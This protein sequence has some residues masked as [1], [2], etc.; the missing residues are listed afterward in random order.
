M[1]TIDISGV[2]EDSL[3]VA[4]YKEMADILKGSSGKKTC[5][6]TSDAQVS[7]LDAKHADSQ[8]MKLMFDSDS[9]AV[10]STQDDKLS[11][12]D[13]VD[14]V[15]V[16]PVD[17]AARPPTESAGGPPPPNQ[18]LKHLV[19]DDHPI[20]NK[21]TGRGTT[22]AILDSGINTSHV[23]FQNRIS[24]ESRSFVEDSIEDIIGHGTQCAGLICG[25]TCSLNING[26]NYQIQGVAPDAKVVMC[27]VTKVLPDGTYGADIDACIQALDHILKY[28][29]RF[30]NVGCVADGVANRVSVVSM[31]F[32][33]PKFHRGLA[34][35]LQEV[36][37]DDI[38][39]VCAGSNDGATDTQPI[40]YPARLGHVLCI[41]SCH[42]GGRN[43][44]FS[45]RGRE[46][47]FL[48]PGENVW[49]PTIGGSCEYR[50][51]TGTSFAAPLV[52]GVVC[53]LV[54]DLVALSSPYSIDALL[55]HNVWG[56]REL[57]KSMS[58]IQGVH[59]EDEGYG[60]LK[61]MKYFKKKTE[62]KKALFLEIVGN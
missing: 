8:P 42:S 14:F 26:V 38:I 22:V 21:P 28:N 19:Y 24:P 39:V 18:C 47:D 57:L 11:E 2:H 44:I 35:K 10:E 15:S 17:E 27:K 40:A 37:S 43:S 7:D 16:E 59:K 45:P 52:A 30:S 48:A 4:Y 9:T 56:M 41:S 62:E 36:V 32:G 49:A 25:A 3:I 31:S 29:K 6:L 53:Q 12:D 1:S 46:L 60:V 23:A 33:M 13:E 55:I 61:P 20:P 34:M 50:A 58:T 5:Y 54:E 51:C